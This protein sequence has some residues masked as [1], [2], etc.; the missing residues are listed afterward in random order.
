VT[1]GRILSRA[2]S[3]PSEAERGHLDAIADDLR[4]TFEERGHHVEVALDA[5]PAFGSGRSRSALMNDLVLET[6]GRSASQGGGVSFQP[7]NGTGRELIG[8]QHRYR[9]RRA[10]R[11]AADEL[12]VTVSS[13]SAIVLE[14]E[15]A[16]FPMENWVFGWI[17]NAEGLI[18][19]VFIAEVLGI[20]AGTPGRLIFGPAL[21]LGS[22]G[23]FGGGFSPTEEDLD[24]GLGDEDDAGSIG[25]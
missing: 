9:I 7:V 18:A 13:E 2:M 11:D 4:E 17:A 23:P 6:V 16:I 14:E 1:F 20:V 15:A 12:I 24:L 10:K 22:G 25:A 8:L 21:A 5:D 19:E 3:L